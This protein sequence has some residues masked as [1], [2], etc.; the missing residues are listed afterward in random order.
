MIA[1]FAALTLILWAYALPCGADSALH[2]L[3]EL[4]G[5]HNTVY[6]LGSIH[7]LRPGD[8]P[9]AP[10]VVNAYANSKSLVMEINLDDIDSDQLSA[11]MLSSAMLP[12]GTID[13]IEGFETE[14]ETGR[15]IRNESIAWLQSRKVS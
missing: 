11:E 13:R 4:H 7:V 5:K 14:G 3:W 12:D 10:A 6:L 1:R 15:W 2:S 8:Y 9:L